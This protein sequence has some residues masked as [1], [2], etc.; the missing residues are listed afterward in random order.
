MK[1]IG[2][3][4]A[5]VFLAIV[6][7]LYMCTYQVRFTEVAI[8]TTLGNP[9]QN[10][11]TDPG[12]GIKWPR[13]IQDMVIYDKRINILEDRTEETRT[14]DGKN[15]LLTTFTL[16]KVTDPTKFHTNFPG[17]VEDGERKLRTTV[18]THKHAVTGTH[19]FSHFVSTDPKTR[20]VRQIEAEIR[21]AVAKDALEEYGIEVVDFGI[22]RLGLPK[23][24]TSAVFESMKAHEDAKAARY[25]AEGR[26]RAADIIAEASA[27]ETRIMAEVDRIVK[28]I[29]T[30][31]EKIVSEYYKKF[32]KYPNLRIL[33]DRLRTVKEALRSRSTIIW[34][35]TE[36]PFDVFDSEVRDRVPV[37]D[38]VLPSD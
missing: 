26:A 15:I 5:A 29:E 28:R 3:L 33:L 11:I 22:K 19:E 1:N 24:V 4:L 10:V 17:G 6:L 18:V 9:G 30:D 25:V 31:A 32:D 37:L 14:V 35:T 13:P 7:V 2:T 16:W 21:D 36:S 23:S 8:K 12:L 27:A 38:G 20:R 34:N